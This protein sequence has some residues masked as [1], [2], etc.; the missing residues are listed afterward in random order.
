MKYAYYDSMIILMKF[1]TAG[2]LCFHVNMIVLN[3]EPTIHL[4]CLHVN[5]KFKISPSLNIS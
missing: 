1:L 2:Y 3:T 4:S 5:D